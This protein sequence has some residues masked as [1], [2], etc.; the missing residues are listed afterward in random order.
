MAKCLSKDK[1]TTMSTEAHKEM[2]AKTSIQSLAKRIV[3][4]NNKIDYRKKAEKS[5]MK[6]KSCS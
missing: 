1:A 4:E 2:C 6:G 5:K 3:T